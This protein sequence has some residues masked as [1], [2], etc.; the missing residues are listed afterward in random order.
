MN[1]VTKR[2]R[3]LMA[4]K[5]ISTRLAASFGFLLFV[6]IVLAF[7]TVTQINKMA[8]LSE[9]FAK[10]DTK[11]LLMVQSL[12]L[13][14]ESSS[15]ALLRLLTVEKQKRIAEYADVDAKNQQINLLI[16]SLAT[17]LN[18]QHQRDTLQKLKVDRQRYQEAY[19]ST[20]N[21]LE[22]EG[23]QPALVTF[24]QQVQPL[25]DASLIES[26]SLLDRESELL[27]LGQFE[28]Q[29]G[30]ERT[31]YIVALLSVASIFIAGLLAWLTIRSVV[32][33]LA[34]LELAAKKIADGDYQ[35]KV[36]RSKT[37]EVERVGQAL[38][39][40]A[41]A[42]ANREQEIEHLAYYDALTNLPNRTLLLKQYSAQPLQHH[43]LVLMDVA[44]L[45]TVN[46]TL[47]FDTGD[48]VIAQVAKR[49]AGLISASEAPL[50]QGQFSRFAGGA[51]AVLFAVEDKALT[52]NFLTQIDQALDAPIVCGHHTVD[53]GLVYGIASASDQGLPLITLLRNAEVALY[54]AKRKNLGRAW[55]SDAQEAS[56]LSHLS[57]LSDLRTAVKSNQLQMWLQPKI[58]LATNQGYGFE[59]LVRWQHPERGFISPAEFVPFAETTGYIG[60]ITEWMLEQ[61]LQFL[62]AWANTHPQLSIAVNV[63]THDL[64]NPHFPQRVQQLL[65][66]YGVNSKLLKLE[67]TESGIMEDPAS[68]IDLLQSLRD[69]GIE[70]SIDDFGT[71]YSSLSYLQRLP[72]NELKIDRSFV[73]D[74]DSLPTNQHLVKTI[75]AMGHGLNLSVIAEGIETAAERDTLIALG[76][77]NMQGY[78]ASKPLHG[79]GLQDWLA[80]QATNPSH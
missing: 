66:Q 31:G 54:A 59:A 46:E 48:T 76:C 64:R 23:Q 3:F 4:P 21:Q 44:R 52:Q 36:S 63:S 6:F 45:K 73:T 17:S 58:H 55:Y 10:T 22:D 35:T 33:P 51:F 74:I 50:A 27:A 75:I 25:L 24:S 72:V 47:G 18:D 67:I 26:N 37:E 42:I 38:N 34:K 69:I 65:Q 13:S 53:I 11:R 57:L 5:R 12:S 60:L 40:M 61:A 41:T 30:F 1:S 49:I 14:I 56:R 71:G 79:K 15:S 62:S 8:T 32:R 68:V 7:V 39:A 70:L 16:A 20:V 43:C 77:D 9:K 28:N 78:F 19:L 80:R 29:K 2:S